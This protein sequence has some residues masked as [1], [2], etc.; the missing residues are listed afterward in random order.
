MRTNNAMPPI[1]TFISL[2]LPSDV[3]AKM[4]GIQ[5][6][7]KTSNAD[8]KW[9]VAEKLHLTL[10]F[11]GNVEGGRLQKLT[12]I[13][14]ASLQTASAFDLVFQSLG[15]FPSL[16]SPRIVWIGSEM[17]PELRD[18]ST[19][20]EDACH[21]LGFERE[22]RPFHPHVTLGRVKGS[23]NIRRLTE[24]LKSLTL[25][26]FQVRCREVCIMRSDL[27][28]TGSTYTLLTSIPLQ[29]QPE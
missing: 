25:E 20:I 14:K 27:H 4:A 9:E 16:A 26:P 2:P 23:R 12:Q 22:D 15:C 5:Q 7:L 28:P 19:R 18:L 29:L 17:K 11:L 21:Q 3:Q 10:K 13:L 6:T 8:V 24:S 1:R